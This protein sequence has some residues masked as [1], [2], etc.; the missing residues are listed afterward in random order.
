MNS[1]H[2]TSQEADEVYFVTHHGSSK[3]TVGILD[4]DG[5]LKIAGRLITDQED[6]SCYTR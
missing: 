4:S 1:N 5:N 6:L 2:S 3:K